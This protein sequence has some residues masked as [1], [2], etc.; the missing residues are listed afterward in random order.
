[1][2]NDTSIEKIEK[3]FIGLIIIENNENEKIY[4]LN[5]SF[6]EKI[7]KILDNNKIFDIIKNILKNY[8]LAF[9]EIKMMNYNKFLTFNEIVNNKFWFTEKAEKENYI[10]VDSGK[11][12]VFFNEEID[13]NNI[14]YIID[15]HLINNDAYNSK[16]FEELFPY[17]EDISI[18][19]L[20][21]LNYNRNDI[22]IDMMEKFFEEKIYNKIENNK[23]RRQLKIRLGIFKYLHSQKFEFFTKT[24]ENACENE[25]DFKQLNNET[26]IECC[27]INIYEHIQRRDKKIKEFEDNFYD[28][29]K[30]IKNT[31]NKDEYLIRFKA[32]R[33][34]CLNS[35][36]EIDKLL[37][38][39]IFQNSTEN[40]IKFLKNENYKNDLEII[41][42][43][44]LK[45]TAK[46][47]FYFY[48]RNPLSVENKNK[49]I[50]I[51]NNFFL[52][53]KLLTI[54]NKNYDVE[55]I[56]FKEKEDYNEIKNINDIEILF[57]YLN[58]KKLFTDLFPDNSN[59][60]KRIKILVLGYFDENLK[61]KN[62]KEMHNRE[63]KNI[64]YIK[65]NAHDQNYNFEN[66]YFFEK[67]FFNFIH[68]F[69]YFLVH[70][71][72]ITIKNAF[73][74]ARNYFN[75]HYS[76]LSEEKYRPIIEIHMVD[77]SEKFKDDQ[78]ENEDFDLENKE[79]NNYILDEYE[80]E[81]EN[82]KKDNVYYRENPFSEII[83][84]EN[85]QIIKL[86]GIESLRDFKKFLNGN[87]YNKDKF[88]FSDKY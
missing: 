38:Y 40:L 58:D 77:E 45:H 4:R 17:I 26:K 28:Y 31:E 53:H 46:F 65:K 51:S 41:R 6:R 54:I 29:I 22:Y 21:L 33:A 81:D 39:N 83:E 71:E 62:F 67:K 3:N 14:Y 36:E 74:N 60:K 19:L 47:K 15:N 42:E 43:R 7:L 2:K 86:P 9:K 50:D 73:Q 55:F 82:S 75:I 27:L 32:L 13:S 11:S 44:I 63:I 69:I 48:L 80:L 56:P 35:I 79:N 10:I 1:M 64:I 23:V 20:I 84:I 52:T 72:T 66:F 57:L 16:E 18:T 87:I 49:Y 59:S 5:I 70:D 8:Y 76:N 30:N 37:K 78:S 61:D 24:L 68:H 25:N 12:S 85:K 34:L 88:T